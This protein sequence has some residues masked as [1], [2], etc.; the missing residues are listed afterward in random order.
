MTRAK[1]GPGHAIAGGL[2]AVVLAA[3]PAMASYTFETIGRFD[4]DPGADPQGGVIAVGDRLYGATEGGGSVGATNH[5]DGLGV[6]YS[7][8]IAGGAYKALDWFNLYTGASP[9]TD[10]TA[11]GNTLY[12][13]TPEGGYGPGDGTI[14]SIAIGPG[15]F[16]KNL[17][18]FNAQIGP[19]TTTLVARGNTLYGA[20]SGGAHGD[21]VIYSEPMTGG[22]IKILFSFN[23][24]TNDRGPYGK[25][26]LVGDTIYGVTSGGGYGNGSVYSYNLT[27]NTYTKLGSF[28]GTNGAAPIQGV[29]LG[30]TQLY[31]ATSAGGA[32]GSGT[33]YSL[34]AAGGVIT[35][36]TSFPAYQG[37]VSG[38]TLVGNMLYG[39]GYYGANFSAG[40]VVF[41]VPTYGGGGAPKTVVTF[42]GH[43]GSSPYPNAGLTL[44]GATLYGTTSMDG[45]PDYGSAADPGYGTVFSLTPDQIVTVTKA[46]ANGF[47]ANVG[48][49]SVVSVNGLPQIGRVRFPATG[50]GHAA[51]TDPDW[52]HDVETFALHLFDKATDRLGPDLTDVVWELNA[53]KYSGFTVTA[54]RI[55]P[56]IN[57]TAPR[58]RFGGAY[59]LFITVRATGTDRSA[60]AF[61]FDLARLNGTPDTLTVD[62][63][64]VLATPIVTA[65][66]AGR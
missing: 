51:V 12:G 21:G 9:N 2:A 23:H 62:Q 65:N 43:N 17:A 44:V 61:G 59:N 19:P 8:P 52:P 16:L 53:A 22:P 48:A 3:S 25:L 60:P 31:G 47:G 39:T 54:S 6:V 63:L 37:A 35:P 49:L 45:S 15:A 38:L 50:I 7:L 58:G 18:S 40:G 56:T 28:N 33:V 4:Y 46:V 32:H 14:F 57:P 26:L 11:V 30:G 55:D 10:L 29:I 1:F 41:A 20:A 13:T 5:G 36:L 27:S 64:A 42:N 34:P 24:A 66:T